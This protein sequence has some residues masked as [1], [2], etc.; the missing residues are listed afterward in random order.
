MDP[1][2]NDHFPNKRQKRRRYEHRHRRE[3]DVK[4]K[5]EIEVMKPQGKECLQLP[6][7]K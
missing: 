3:G 4:M 7:V 1:I 5:A 2:S 6:E